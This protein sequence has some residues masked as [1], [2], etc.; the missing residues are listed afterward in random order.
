MIKGDFRMTEKDFKKLKHFLRN[1][2]DSDTEEVISYVQKKEQKGIT[3]LEWKEIFEI[4]C[5]GRM[6][7]FQK[8]VLENKVQLGKED[9]K[10][11]SIIADQFVRELE[12][13]KKMADMIS[14]LQKHFPEEFK[15]D[16]LGI[17]FVLACK[18]NNIYLVKFLLEQGCDV[19]YCY[20]KK[21]GIQEA[22]AYS[23]SIAGDGDKTLYRYLQRNQNTNGELEDVEKFYIK[24][25]MGRFYTPDKN[26]CEE[27]ENK[28]LSPGARKQAEF[29]ASE[30]DFCNLLERETT[31]EVLAAFMEGYNWDD[32]LEVPYFIAMHENCELATALK[33][34]W[35]GEGII[36]LEEGL[37]ETNNKEW[38][39][40]IET[41]YQRISDG[42]YLQKEQHYEIPINNTCRLELRK[43]GVADIFLNDL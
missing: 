15:Q 37:D 6:A 43:K 16:V 40:L 3:V 9:I 34:F 8:W 22:L 10:S 1:K 30:Y 20:K 21:T 36:M 23:E 28:L 35:E 42:V 19:N 7:G 12:E 4:A 31:G 13:C 26:S 18:N 41:V 14:E 33:I 39:Y 29:V 17:A 32:G 27:Y 24:G 2:E 5:E 11:V 38:K 25:L